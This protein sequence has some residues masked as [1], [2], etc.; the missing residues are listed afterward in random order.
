MTMPD[1]ETLLFDVQD[2][3]A[4]ITLNRPEVLNAISTKCNREIIAAIEAVEDSEDIKA[5]IFKGAGRAFC[6]GADVKEIREFKGEAIRRY[7]ELDFATKNAIAE[8]RKPTIAAIHSHCAGGGCATPDNSTGS[9]RPCGSPAFPRAAIVES[10]CPDPAPN[11]SSRKC[12]ARLCRSRP[13]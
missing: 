2:G 10:A 11:H 12:R 6:A 1:F 3:V 8:C 7:I 13:L 9:Q 4:T 5:C